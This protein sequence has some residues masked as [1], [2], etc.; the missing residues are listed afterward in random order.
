M[1]GR[2]SVRAIEPTRNDL[3]AA[4]FA[5]R[6]QAEAALSHLHWIGLPDDRLELRVP[7]PGHYGVE[8]H[9]SSEL[10]GAALTGIIFGGPIGSLL[11]LALFAWAF[12]EFPISGMLLG[13][14]IGAFWGAFYGG[15]IGMARTVATHLDDISSWDIVK[16]GAETIVIARAGGRAH[17]ARKVLHDRGALCYLTEIPPIRRA[18]TTVSRT[19]FLP[20]RRS[21]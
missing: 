15:V 1:S 9:L 3:I 5:T 2:A 4:V 8:D 21:A 10:G 17:A 19:Y 13:V 11:G 14:M 6:D 16:D 12:S 7:K 18:T 20:L